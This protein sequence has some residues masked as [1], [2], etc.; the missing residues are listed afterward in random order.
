MPA[1]FWAKDAEEFTGSL[2][3]SRDGKPA[4]DFKL[5]VAGPIAASATSVKVE[6]RLD[7]WA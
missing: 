4:V 5:I 1:H 7:L 6:L 3:I 2:P